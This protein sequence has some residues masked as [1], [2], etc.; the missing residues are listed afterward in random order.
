MATTLDVALINRAQRLATLTNGRVLRVD[1]WLDT[2]GRECAPERAVACVVGS[3]ALG[4]RAVDLSQYTRLPARPP[5][6]KSS[7]MPAS[8]PIFRRS[9][10]EDAT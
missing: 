7:R 8:V 5:E 9:K 6:F 1:T 3:D 4:W 10:P 2:R